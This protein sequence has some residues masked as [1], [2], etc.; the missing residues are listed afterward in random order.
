MS[1][2]EYKSG[3]LKSGQIRI[4]PS[5]ISTLIDNQYGWYKSNIL[6]EDRF[7]G[8]SASRLGTIIHHRIEHFYKGTAHNKQEEIDWLTKE[9]EID[10]WAITEAIEPMWEVWL[11]EYGNIY[12]KMDKCEE[13][14][15]FEPNDN[16]KV[17]GTVDGIVGDTIVDWKT[18]STKKSSLGD[19]KYQLYMYAYLARELGHT[20]NNVSVC[21]IVKPTKTLPAR[22]FVITEPIEDE[23]MSWLI[24]RVQLES[25]LLVECRD[26]DSLVEKY[27][28]PNIYSFRQ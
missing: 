5:G 27:Y 9:G 22:V 26:D 25:R 18:T 2:G 24:A 17:S 7:T 13:W 4:S 14:L 8:N 23:A 21:Y 28:R 10:I 20:I 3:E 6:K 19:Y 11:K 15:E 12:P 1:L 16:I